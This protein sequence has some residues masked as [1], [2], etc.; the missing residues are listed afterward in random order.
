MT[1]TLL[2]IGK[3]L[4]K[5]LQ[6]LITDYQKRLSHYIKFNIDVIADVKNTKNLSEKQQK[7]QEG[8][9][10]LKKLQPTDLVMLLDETGTN[11]TSTAFATHL[12]KKFHSGNK[13]LVFVIGG[14]YGFSESVYRHVHEKIAFSKMTF[15]HEMIRL[16]FVEQ[17]YRA[18]TI[19]KNEPYHH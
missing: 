2:V 7:E 8:K 16:F 13:R 10:I 14:A 5:N 15:S 1:I 4:H 3:T 12:E 6:E 17:L 9:Y 18:F 11:F 19:L